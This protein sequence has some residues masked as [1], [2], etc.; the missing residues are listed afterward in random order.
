MSHERPGALSMV[1]INSITLKRSMMHR[2]FVVS[3]RRAFH[4]AAFILMERR[5]MI[6]EQHQLPAWTNGEA[7]IRLP[8]RANHITMIRSWQIFNELKAKHTVGLRLAVCLSANSPPSSSNVCGKQTAAW[9]A[10]WAS[11]H[12]PRTAANLQKRVL[13]VLAGLFKE[14]FCI[15]DD[16]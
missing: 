9:S 5:R 6:E 11:G 4:Q 8:D 3:E 12:Q 14:N 16:S 1:V 15:Y 7:Q 13:W 2:D 10:R